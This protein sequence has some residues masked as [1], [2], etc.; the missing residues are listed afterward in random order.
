M[1]AYVHITSNLVNQEPQRV[2]Q[3]DILIESLTFT[4]NKGWQNSNWS[5]P[6]LVLVWWI[7]WI[8]LFFICIFDSQWFTND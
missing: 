1:Y 7:V 8:I 5:K 6:L 4:V 2:E 3:C